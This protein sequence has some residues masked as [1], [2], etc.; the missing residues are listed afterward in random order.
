MWVPSHRGIS[1]LPNSQVK[2]ASVGWFFPLQNWKLLFFLEMG[3]S[4]W[5]YNRQYCADCQF[6]ET[7]SGNDNLTGFG[8]CVLKYSAGKLV[9]SFGSYKEKLFLLGFSSGKKSNSGWDVFPLYWPCQGFQGF[10]GIASRCIDLRR[11]VWVGSPPA[12]KWGTEGCR[13]PLCSQHSLWCKAALS[14]TSPQPA[15]P[16]YCPVLL[17]VW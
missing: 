4:Y 11:H 1:V 7:L 17:R 5:L 9:C 14:A 13:C 3:I 8:N 10:W 6:R 12:K 2:Q 16:T 15:F